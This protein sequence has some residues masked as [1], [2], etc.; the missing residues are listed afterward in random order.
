MTPVTLLSFLNY[1]NLDYIIYLAIPTIYY[2]L[3]QNITLRIKYIL[4]FI[5]IISSIVLKLKI[6]LSEIRDY[7]TYAKVMSDKGYKHL[8]LLDIIYE[9]YLM[10]LSKFLLKILSISKLLELYYSI[11]FFVS[12]LFFSWLAFVK[13]IQPWKRAILFNLFFTLFTF[14]LLR[15]SIACFILAFYFYL[16]SKSIKSYLLYSSIIF[17]ISVFP[18]IL[19]DFFKK[20][21]LDYYIILVFVFILICILF[22]FF[23]HSSLLYSKFQDFKSRS[24]LYNYTF[25]NIVF[26]LTLLFFL[27]LWFYFKN[28]LNNY[29]YT[30]IFITYLMLYFFNPVIGF[31]FSFYIF[32]Y[33]LMNTKLFF[34][35]KIESILNRYSFLFILVGFLSFK[36]FLFA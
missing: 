14:V 1:I 28:I 12:I 30:L 11:M 36:L 19:F 33:L 3:S 10:L 6:P 9:P 22:L 35:S 7:P 2:F 18:I 27:C 25:H 31:R 5:F 4:L 15:N 26:F 20:R 34:N 13:D 16:S 17:H 8:A 23:D 32:L 21:K 29:F 24:H